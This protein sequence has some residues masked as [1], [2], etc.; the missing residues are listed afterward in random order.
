MHRLF[1]NP[2]AL[3][4]E[5]AYPQPLRSIQSRAALAAAA[6]EI[7]SWPGYAPTPLVGLPGL[8]AHCG[9]ARLWYKD[10]GGRFGLGS[11]KALGGAYAVFRLL[12]REIER[13]AGARVRSADLLGGRFRPVTERITVVCATDGNHGRAVAWGARLFGC[14]CTVYL[15]ER[16]SRG[17]EE[18]IARHGARIVRTPGNYDDSV[19]QA[20]LDARRN[21]WFVVSDTS[22]EGYVD[23][24]RDVM[25][26]YALMV[27]EAVS[28]LPEGEWPTH[29]F[30]QGG[31]GGLA[32][33]ACAWLW[34]TAG[35]RRPRFVVVEPEKADCLF[36]SA[37]AGRPVRVCG[38]LDTLMAGLAC[39]EPSLIAWRVLELGA[40][41]F[42]TIPDE[43]AVECMRMLARGVGHDPAIVAG[44]S[45]VAGLAGML[46]AR[47]AGEIGLG[48]DARVLVFG[49]EGATD[50]VLYRRLVDGACP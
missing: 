35:A 45:A 25:Q 42:L 8:A 5:R 26:G 18:A 1:L 36:Q 2:R 47:E 29:V 33:S 6:R 30:V 20:A 22:Y 34:E 15:H 13:Q 3:G 7:R 28:Q 37:A 4:P 17:R 32:A 24:P 11:F 19:R 12:A 44:E 46:A 10:E 49:T 43:A 27:E 39:G 14:Q 21:G 31:V 9:I 48:P 23:V 41:A 40:D 50:P 16:V 38:E